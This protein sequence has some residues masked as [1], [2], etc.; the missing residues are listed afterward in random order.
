MITSLRWGFA[1]DDEVYDALLTFHL[2][3]RTFPLKGSWDGA[4]DVHTEHGD[5]VTACT[6]WR[7]L[8]VVHHVVADH[9]LSNFS[10]VLPDQL[11]CPLTR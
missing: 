2:H 5:P 11:I 6:R 10:F 9:V 7:N 4:S 1:I 8:R 3:V